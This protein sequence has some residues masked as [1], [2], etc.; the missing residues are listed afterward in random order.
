MKAT[1]TSQSVVRRERFA[2]DN[3]NVDAKIH[4]LHDFERR[5]IG[6]PLNGNPLLRPR[7]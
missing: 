7:V 3:S 2:A 4:S 1:P 6:T 5:K